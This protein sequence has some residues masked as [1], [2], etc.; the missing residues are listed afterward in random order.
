[1]Y[2]KILGNTILCVQY[3]LGNLR[4]KKQTIKQFVE[5]IKAII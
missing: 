5:M 2:S 1:M 3:F 4:N